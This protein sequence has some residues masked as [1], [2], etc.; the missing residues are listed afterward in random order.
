[1]PR[2]SR[3]IFVGLKLCVSIRQR[4]FDFQGRTRIMHENRPNNGV[5]LHENRPN[6]G[7]KLHENRPNVEITGVMRAWIFVMVAVVVGNLVAAS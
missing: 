6:N 3:G 1:M 4:A 7:V 2:I 5:K